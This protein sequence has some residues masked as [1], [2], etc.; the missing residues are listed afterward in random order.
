MLLGGTAR[1][2]LE[3]MSMGNTELF[4]QYS[5]ELGLKTRNA[6]NLR[7]ERSLLSMFQ[8]FLG[9]RPPTAPLAKRFI[10]GFKGAP[11][12]ILRYASTIKGFMKFCGDPLDDLKLPTPKQIPAYVEDADYEKLLLAAGQKRSH[13][14]LVTR[15]QLLIKLARY[16]GLRRAEQAE[17][18]MRDIHTD[19]IMVREGKGLKDRVIPLPPA[20]AAELNRFCKGRPSSEKVFDLSEYEISNKFTLWAKKA[21]VKIHAHS[22]RHKYA[23][24]L[25]E[26]GA[27]IIQI[28]T[29]LGHTDIGTTQVYLGISDKGLREAVDRL[30]NSTGSDAKKSPSQSKVL[31]SVAEFE[32]KTAPLKMGTNCHSVTFFTMNVVSQNLT[33]ETVEAVTSEPSISYRLMLYS[34]DPRNEYYDW[35]REDLIQMRLV[36]R[37]RLNQPLNGLQISL[38]DNPPTLYVGIVLSQQPMNC[39]SEDIDIKTGLPT[40]SFFEKP[41]QINVT[42]RYRQ[43]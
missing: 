30:E 9:E 33:L 7:H 25:L 19:F 36:S 17:L 29:L 38:P 23:Q 10:A 1:R 14:E 15:D 5:I 3:V 2:R 40:L 13:K 39:D 37:R 18:E 32:V 27:D 21:G 41:V 42:L 16:S 43:V 26:S 8:T 12:T 4:E 31:T 6:V 28:M 35:E 24:S 22:L 20:I 34:E 11:A